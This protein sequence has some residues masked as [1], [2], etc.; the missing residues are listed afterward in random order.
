MTQETLNFLIM[1]SNKK[2]TFLFNDKDWKR[3]TEVNRFFYIVRI[4]I[5]LN[6]SDRNKGNL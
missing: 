4:I 1:K 5:Y 3:S 2:N 6:K